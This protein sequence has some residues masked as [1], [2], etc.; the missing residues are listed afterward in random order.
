MKGIPFCQVGNGT[1]G[2]ENMIRTIKFD[3]LGVELNSF[4]V[5]ASLE[6]FVSKVLGLCERI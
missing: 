1:V 6:G 4:G 3:G 2:V 5:L